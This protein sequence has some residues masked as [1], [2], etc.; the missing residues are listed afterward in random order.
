MYTIHIP[1]DDLTRLDYWLHDPQAV[2]DLQSMGSDLDGGVHVMLCSP[3]GSTVVA[4][5]SFQA[6]V[7]CWVAY[8]VRRTSGAG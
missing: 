6:E 2:A 5:L 1:T 4:S 3:S 7:N 8:P